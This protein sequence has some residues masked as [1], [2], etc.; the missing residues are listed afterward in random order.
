MLYKIQT[1]CQKRGP[2]YTC[3]DFNA[4]VQKKESFMESCIGPHTFDR[5]NVHLEQQDEGVRENRRLF[6][7][8]C[9]QTKTIASN[10]FFEKSDM[11]L[12]T[13]RATTTPGPRTQAWTTSARTSPRSSITGRRRGWRRRCRGRRRGR[14]ARVCRAAPRTMICTHSFISMAC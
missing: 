12:V 5:H 10:T 11:N 8:H 14:R 13:H 3:G 6:I 2:T 7:N 9:I 1:K 4:R